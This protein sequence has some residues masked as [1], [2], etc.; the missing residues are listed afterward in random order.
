MRVSHGVPRRT[1]C[2]QTYILW[3]GAGGRGGGEGDV[4]TSILFVQ[5][6]YFVYSR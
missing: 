2:S 6:I 5:F 4:E 1:W 3:I